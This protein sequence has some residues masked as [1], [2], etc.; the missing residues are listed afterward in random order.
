VLVSSVVVT[1]VVLTLLS[2]PI[3]FALGLAGFTGL[4]VGNFSLTKLPSSLVFGNGST[5]RA[6]FIALEIHT[7]CSA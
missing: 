3:V 2:L 1:F 5:A 7:V 6:V 4:Y